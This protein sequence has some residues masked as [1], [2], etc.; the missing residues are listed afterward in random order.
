MAYGI[1]SRAMDRFVVGTG[2]C[3]STL[4]S[5]ML[6]E[7]ATLL[8]VFEF[9]NGLDMSKRFRGEPMAGEAFAALISQEHP[10][11]TMV[12]SRGYKVEEIT[13][14]FE[15]GGA[16]YRR[17]DR[18]PW[19]LVSTLPRLTHDPDA[20]F[21]ETVAFAATLPEQ[22]PAVH[23]RALFDWLAA[24][25]GRRCWVE[26]SGSSIDY[27]GALH[28]LFPQARFVHIHRDGLETALSMREHAAY[29]LAISFMFKLETDQQPSIAQLREL[30][31]GAPPSADDPISRMLAS[32]PPVEYFGRY[33]TEELARGF[34][35]VSKLDAAQYLDVRFEDLVAGPK[36]TMRAIG[37]FFELGAE[38][39]DWTD[40]A[41]ALVR[42]VPP[43][44]F[45]A[46]TDEEQRRLTD[47]CRPGMQLLGRIP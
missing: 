1:M 33:W 35:A 37:D 14:P 8:S 38:P 25:L 36:A 26:R 44:R 10:F 13:Y 22:P 34:R 19:V 9:F 32:R 43:T 17:D 27:L 40:R 18:L 30:E 20:L 23:Y 15:R 46:L 28:E 6:A 41:A 11:V 24:R 31:P 2:R 21:D 7:N 39:P 45:G 47:A 12:L 3:G 5:R 42:G 29:R 16:R 4:L